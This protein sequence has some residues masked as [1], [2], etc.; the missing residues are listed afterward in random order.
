[1]SE[2]RLI[3]DDQQPQQ[4]WNEQAINPGGGQGRVSPGV[5]M[6]TRS[7]GFPD[8]QSSDAGH[9]VFH[10]HAGCVFGEASCPRSITQGNEAALTH[11]YAN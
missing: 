6:V 5:A 8:S 10:Q 3:E 11:H 2:G 7:V 4:R 9:Q 1:M